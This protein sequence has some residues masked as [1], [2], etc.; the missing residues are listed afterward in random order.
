MKGFRAKVRRKADGTSD[1]FIVKG[2][3]YM[4]DANGVYWKRTVETD[5]TFSTPENAGTNQ[6]KDG[7]C[8]KKS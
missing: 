1:A 8:I 3:L 5:G 7:I 6:P 4:Q 2:F